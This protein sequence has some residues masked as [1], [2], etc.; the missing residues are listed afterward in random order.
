M[1]TE[2]IFGADL[3]KDTPDSVIEV[4]KYMIGDTEAKPKYFPFHN[5]RCECLFRSSSYYFGV[6]EPVCKLWKDDIGKNWVLSTRSNIK[7]YK[8]EI[9][10]FLDWIKPY[11]DGG[12]G[13]RD[14]YAIVT[15]EEAGTP[16]IYYLR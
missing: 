14:M 15:Y 6:N 8:G 1:Y 7:N 5:G 12:S 11:I 13:Y 4:L 10:A 16:D 2:L 9:E 3:K